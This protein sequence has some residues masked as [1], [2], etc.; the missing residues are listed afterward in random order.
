MRRAIAATAVTAAG[1]VWLL[2]YKTTP[3]TVTA[4]GSS[5]AA[6]EEPSPSTSGATPAPTPSGPVAGTFS[7]RVVTTIFGDTQV[8]VVVSGG[9][10]SDVQAVQLPYDRPRSALI[11][12]YAAPILRSEAISA[13]SAR[14]DVVS[15][16]TFTSEA[17]AQSLET[18]LA[19]DHL[20]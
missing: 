4:L 3:H 15:G 19:Q 17:Y 10:V 12:N 20:G 5:Q 14:I 18:A 9:H 16:A 11:S 1:I 13:Q 7:G 6:P 2:A 8:R